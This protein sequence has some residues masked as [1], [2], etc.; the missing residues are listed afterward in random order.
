MKRL[1]T[2]LICIF[3]ATASLAACTNTI[4]VSDEMKAASAVIIG[5]VMETRQVPQA[6]DSLDGTE[7]VVHIDKKV[8]GKQTDE[9]TVFSEHSDNRVNLQTGR[10]YLLFL[11]NDNQHWSINTCGNSGP[12]EEESAVVKQIGHAASN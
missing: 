11:T 12:M 3:S 5:T 8:K 7:Y 10:Q 6:W 9:I 2:G 4:P 1:A